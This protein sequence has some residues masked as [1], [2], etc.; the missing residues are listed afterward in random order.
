MTTAH[1]DSQF[2]DYKVTGVED[3]ALR[4][5]DSMGISFS[6]LAH[7]PPPKVGDTVRLFGRG[8]GYEIRGIALVVNGKVACVYSYQT[9]DEQKRAHERWKADRA[10]KQRVDWEAK[11]AEHQKTIASWPAPFQERLSFFM[12]K[13]GWGPEFGPYEIFVCG[14]AVK[15]AEACKTTAGVSAFSKAS[16]KDQA[17]LVPTLSPEHSGN[18]F[19]MAVTLAALFLEKPELLPKMH[20]AICRLVGCETYGCYASTPAARRD[21]SLS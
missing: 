14:E 16:S 13:D 3:G 6:N 17:A 1:T 19:S 5:G 20:G 11:K 12:K 15:I 18:T 9:E 10:A 7:L 4:I 8:M 21:A 2:Q